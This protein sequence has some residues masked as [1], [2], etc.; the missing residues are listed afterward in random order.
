MEQ[1]NS[2]ATFRPSFPILSFIGPFREAGI[3]SVHGSRS[4]CDDDTKRSIKVGSFIPGVFTEH[5]GLK[6]CCN[7]LGHVGSLK[8]FRGAGHPNQARQKFRGAGR[9]SARHQYLK[10]SPE[11]SQAFPGVA[12]LRIILSVRRKRRLCQPRLGLRASQ[13]PLPRG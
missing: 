2:A 5:G 8:Q 11:R 9:R 3:V 12:D 13:L 10:T 1:G 4:C 7:T 6:L